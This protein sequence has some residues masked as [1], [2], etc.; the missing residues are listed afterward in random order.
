MFV[1]TVIRYNRD[2]YNRVWLYPVTVRFL[3]NNIAFYNL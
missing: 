3:C 2:R 1:L